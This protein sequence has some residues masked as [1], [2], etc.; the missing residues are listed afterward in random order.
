MSETEERRRG[1]FEGQVLTKL[2]NLETK[3]DEVKEF[4]KDIYEKVAKNSTDIVKQKS[5]LTAIGIFAGVA[6]SFIKGL[7]FGSH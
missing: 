1:H 2:E 4:K 6:G 5:W 7:L 3:I